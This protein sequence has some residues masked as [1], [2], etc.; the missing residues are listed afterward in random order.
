[1]KIGR[2]LIQAF[3]LCTVLLILPAL[4]QAQFTFTTNNGAITITG[5]TG[6]G[7]NIVIP[8]VINGYPVKNIGMYAFNP[9]PTPYVHQNQ[10]TSVVI[11]DSVTN[12]E[13]S[14]FYGCSQLTNVVMSTNVTE[15]SVEVFGFSGLTSFTFP[16]GLIKIDGGAF[17]NCLNLTNVVIPSGVQ[18]IG[19]YAFN[20]SYS[21]TSV[22][23]P[24]SVIYLGDWSFS[25]C[26]NITNLTIG[27]GITSIAPATFTWCANL[28]TVS[29]P[30]S[31][32]N[33][34]TTY[35]Y[36]AFSD[37]FALTNITYGSGLG[38]NVGSLRF[39]GT[40]NLN[41]ITVS[42]NNP[43][44]SSLN[45]VLF[46]KN[47][48][49]LIQCPICKAGIY[50]IPNTVTSLWNQ[51][52]LNC[53]R[54]TDITMGSSII[55]SGGNIFYGCTGITNINFLDGMTN[56]LTG[57]FYP[58]VNLESFAV[59]LNNPSYNSISGVL[60]DKNQTTLIQYPYN[61]NE[62]YTVPNGVKCIADDAFAYC[63]GL[64]NLMF[65]NSLTNI[66]QYAF[67]YCSGLKNITIPNG[68]ASIDDGTFAYCSNLVTA[69]ISSSVTNLGAYAF[70]FCQNLT[71]VYFKGNAPAADSSA[72]FYNP[73]DPFGSWIIPATI[74]YLPGTIG[75]SNS[76][77][78]V[79]TALWLPV[80]QTD[81]SV[82]IST[83]GFGFNINWASGQAVVMEVSTN[84]FDWETVQTNMLTTDSSYF[85]DPQWTNYPGRFYRLRSP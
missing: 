6:S 61:G 31:V 59:S 5:Y 26:I 44:L 75:W 83:N 62:N 28:T 63:L 18:Y 17:D 27:D 9:Y 51:A 74:Y 39:S 53:I 11:P 45:G 85:S 78:S 67:I 38:I 1:M 33:I 82:G 35:Y 7:G 19:D 72:F 54:L 56:L 41:T 2:N 13:F 81:T 73:L 65:P 52:F 80:I 58:C 10:V 76:L 48:T 22:T 21:M 64:T 49:T 50:S 84:L 79:P 68:V 16:S 20:D 8:S 32:T 25:G 40:T 77:A 24:D 36:S 34:G 71:S 42:S 57:L 60:F 70:G 3:L 23:I 66:G 4:A 29:I 15:L 55:S 37:C 46:D 43:V 12:I 47:Q 14:A 69:E 30:D